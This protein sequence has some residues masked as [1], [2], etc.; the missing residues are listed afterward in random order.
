MA[1]SRVNCRKQVSFHAHLT[2]TCCKAMI[3]Y[4]VNIDFVDKRTRGA[5]HLFP[6]VKALKIVIS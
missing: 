1:L 3:S 4:K 5:A 6:M 2:A